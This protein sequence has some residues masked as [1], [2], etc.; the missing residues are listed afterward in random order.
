MWMDVVDLRDFYSSPLGGTARRMI[1]RRI[2]ETNLF[3]RRLLLDMLGSS[4]PCP[5]DML[6]AMASV[7][8]PSGSPLAEDAWCMET[9][10]IWDE[11]LEEHRIEVPVFPFPAPP[12][13]LLR[14]SSYLYTQEADM[15][16]LV[17]ALASILQRSA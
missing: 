5:E 8:L 14:I 6:A 16:R 9:D 2:R 11:L 15:R 17:E 4:P 12:E 13:R 1:R 3:G 7:Q 10:P